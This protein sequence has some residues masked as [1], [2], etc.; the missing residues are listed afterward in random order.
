MNGPLHSCALRF[1]SPYTRRSFLRTA[2]VGAGALTFVPGLL[3]AFAAETVR[4]RLLRATPESQ[5]VASAGILSFLEAV[6]KSRHE[7]HSLMILRHG[8]VLAE[9]WWT[10]YRPEAPHML[11][12]LS[13][14]FTSTAIGFAVAEGRLTVQDPVISFFRDELP[15]KV[16]ENLAR[17]Q[18][19][20]LLSMAVGHAQDSTGSLWGQE[21]WVRTF[22][23]LPIPNEPG[24]R[25]LYN[26]GA[27]YMLSAIIQKVTGQ[28][29]LNY[30]E[31]RLFKP[32]HIANATWEVCPRGID[33]G[34]WGLKLQTESLAKFG[35]LYLQKGMWNGKQVLPA[36]W[37]EEATTFKIQQPAPDLEAAKKHS[38]WH[39]GYCYQFWRCRHNGFRGD[40]AF[41]QYTVVLPERDVV[42]V[43]TSETPDMP[44]ELN[45]IYEHLLPAVKDRA[46][47]RDKSANAAL[48]AR[49]ENLALP[50]PKGIN[51]QHRAT[52]LTGKTFQIEENP[53]GIRT[54]NFEFRRSRCVFSAGT[55]DKL[56][57]VDCGLE[58][59]V[60]GATGMPGTPP[61][62]TRGS[63]G[64]AS[65]VAA[66][67]AWKDENTFEMTWRFYETPHH[68]KVTCRFDGSRLNV[69]FLNSMAAMNPGSKDQRPVL[70]GELL[71]A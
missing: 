71:K 41:G 13:K 44:G 36:S 16:S 25:F 28:R 8:R 33:T 15:D 45:L 31:Q 42:I 48:E 69:E 12:S 59:W 47:P 7:F 18:V 52:S 68:D 38:D 53:L 29:V 2:G 24:T 62:L 57:T 27:T 3:G 35:Q 51:R 5:G 21:N 55:A 58:K 26:S 64:P 4:T 61:K 60:D 32:L 65:R 30:L 22:L 39:Q 70:K 6:A 49:L 14:S 9:G 66:S 56:H 43:I 40:G 67:G 20:H 1:S 11:Y 46:L 17:L 37:I 23:A 34:G 10:P 19:Q 63:L 54:V 50:A